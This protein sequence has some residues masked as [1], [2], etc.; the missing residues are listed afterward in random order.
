MAQGV[1]SYNDHLRYFA[2]RLLF[3]ALIGLIF[4]GCGRVAGPNAA[5]PADETNSGSSST[6]A[7]ETFI[8]ILAASELSV[9]VNRLPL[10]ILRNGAPLNDPDL[11]LHLRYSYLDG[12]DQ[13]AVQ[14][15][16]DAVY[17]G[18]GLPVGLY[19]AYATLD[20]PGGW[21]LE[22]EIPRPDG[23]SQT[24][25]IRLD[26]IE[27]SRI[28]NV[29]SPAIPSKNLTINDVP[30][31]G[32]ISTDTRPD[33]D[34]YKLN[35]ADAIAA[36]KPFLVAFSTPGYCRTAVC[37]PNLQVIKQLKDDFQGQVNFIHVEVYPYPFSESV[38]QQRHVPAMSA[39]NLVTEP[40]TFLV[41]GNGII[42]ARYE[43]GIT[44][45]EL[46]P[47]LRQL[48]AGEPVTPQT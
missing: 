21:S 38:Q 3:L 1:L 10:G 11:T 26:V 30:D 13:T 9:G 24:K 31:I 43:G 8:P 12:T 5:A 35:V 29:G 19:V 33:P 14:G 18:E 23:E 28:P 44:F 34:L 41:D 37:G 36:N 2:R 7:D 25:R 17:R 40:W 4:A 6:S 48:A 39:W 16:T 15:E 47:A 32:Q 46:E 27:Q 22:V 42:Q 20:K 45:T